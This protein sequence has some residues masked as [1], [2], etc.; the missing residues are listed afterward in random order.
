[1]KDKFSDHHYLI[2]TVRDS[3]ADVQTK[4]HTG[5]YAYVRELEQ[6]RKIPNKKLNKKNSRNRSRQMVIKDGAWRVGNTFIHESE[7]ID[8]H[9]GPVLALL[10]WCSFVSR[11]NSASLQL[12][13]CLSSASSGLRYMYLCVRSLLARKTVPILFILPSGILAGPLETL[14]CTCSGCCNWALHCTGS[15]MRGQTRVPSLRI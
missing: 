2:L 5:S 11:D 3:V 12:S 4:V 10:V 13:F 1:M 8:C 7:Q 14:K 15:V 6:T 9:S